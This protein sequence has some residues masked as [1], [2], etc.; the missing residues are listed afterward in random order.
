MQACVTNAKN[1]LS[2]AQKS[3]AH[4]ACLSFDV[5]SLKGHEFKVLK[6]QSHSWGEGEESYNGSYYWLKD[7]GISS[8]GSRSCC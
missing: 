2:C 8:L 6:C 7:Q 5:C 3:A 1:S 4:K